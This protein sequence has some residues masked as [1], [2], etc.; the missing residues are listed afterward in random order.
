LGV[1]L[2]RER[3]SNRVRKTGSCGVA[4]IKEKGERGVGIWGGLRE[5]KD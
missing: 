1:A 3:E 5:N 2:E 4:G